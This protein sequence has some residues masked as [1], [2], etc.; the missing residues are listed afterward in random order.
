MQWPV[1][2][3][4]AIGWPKRQSKPRLMH[5][6]RSW[7]PSTTPQFLRGGNKTKICGPALGQ[8]TDIYCS[9]S[10]TRQLKLCDRVSWKQCVS[11]MSECRFC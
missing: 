10:A 6:W 7:K 5:T 1:T 3:K 11:S 8:L 2:L 9:V 4:P